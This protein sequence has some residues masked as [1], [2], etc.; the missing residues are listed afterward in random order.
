MESLLTIDTNLCYLVFRVIFFTLLA[1]TQSIDSILEFEDEGEEELKGGNVQRLHR[2]YL[3]KLQRDDK[4]LSPLIKFQETN[5]CKEE[6]R[7]TIILFKFSSSCKIWK[8]RI[9]R[10]LEVNFGDGEL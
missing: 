8:W 4:E 5:N 7:E 9:T 3:V 2:G 1:V 6:E 10:S